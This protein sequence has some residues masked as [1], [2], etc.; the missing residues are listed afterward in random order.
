M[1]IILGTMQKS[2]VKTSRDGIVIHNGGLS[3]VNNGGR[4][5]LNGQFNAQVTSVS[6]PKG[7]ADRIQISVKDENIAREILPRAYWPKLGL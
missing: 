6:V 4:V 2:S 7:A 3:V 5:V 1:T